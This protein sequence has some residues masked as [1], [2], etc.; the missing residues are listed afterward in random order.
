MLIWVQFFSLLIINDSHIPKVSAN[1]LYVGGSG[2]GNYSTIQ[3]AVNAANPGDT[4]F[5]YAGTYQENVRIYKTINLTGISHTNTTIRDVPGGTGYPLYIN[6]NYVNVSEL[7]I[8]FSANTGMQEYAGIFFNYANYCRI[9]HCSIYKNRFGIRMVT[10]YF[11]LIR[12][13]T[14]T[15]N[16]W[17]GIRL[18]GTS[19][20]NT[21]VN[22]T[23]SSNAGAAV[24][25][26][27]G[28]ENNVSNNKIVTNSGHAIYMDST[29]HNIVLNNSLIGHINWCCIY[30]LNMFHLAF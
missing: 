2:S 7:M 21:I 27:G 3:A 1:T 5:V 23:I 20:N 9:E 6:A 12:N 22:N 29:A 17:D 18:R 19:V 16:T 10:S 25:I 8:A 4:V 30:I 14:I 11:N 24:S 13:N 26:A 15:G 28:Y